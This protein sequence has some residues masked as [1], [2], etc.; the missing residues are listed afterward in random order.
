[1]ALLENYHD[2]PDDQQ[3]VL[4]CR[5]GRRSTRAARYL[6]SKGYDKVCVLQGGMLKWEAEGLFEAL[7]K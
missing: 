3:I 4:V 7:G 5:R 2:L 6:Q 1:M